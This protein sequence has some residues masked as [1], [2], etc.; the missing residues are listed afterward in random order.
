MP[1]H[2]E[3]VNL[4]SNR[5]RFIVQGFFLSIAVA[6]AD[7]STVLPLIVD[8]FGGGKVLVGVLSSLMKGGAVIM[9]L[10]TAFKA[11]EHPIVLGSLKKVFVFRFLTWFFVG[12]SILIFADFSNTLI[13]ILI[14]IFLF[15]FSFSAG[16]GVIYYQELLGKSFTKEYRGKAISYKQIAAG[17][18]GILSGG[19]S[20]FILERFSKP[21]SF[22]YL[23]LVSGI[24]MA[25]GFL[26]FWNFKEVPKKN[27]LKREQNFGMFLKNAIKLFN[28]DK[29]LK[30][31]VFSRLL[32]Y[33]LFLILPFVILKAKSDFGVSG[34]AVGL[35]IS[36]Q[37]A[38][39]VISNFF[40]G[41]LSG[42]NRN[43]C[44]VLI[45]FV[46]AISAVAL[47][48]IADEFWYFYIVYFLTGAAIDGFRLAFSNLIL[49]ISPED[50]RPMYVAVQNNLSSIGLFFPI[51]GGIIYKSF[52]YT[53][54]SIFT[55]VLLIIGLGISF[56]LR[57]E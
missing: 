42:R 39:A 57:K 38:G 28:S 40:W 55:F 34:K 17:I 26:I 25:I 15:L 5:T 41:R 50:K 1:K 51:L 32:S 18:A 11:Q 21:E 8:Y 44:I 22:S 9:Q 19:L 20:G 45:S 36:V 24:I 54:L 14:S 29:T 35:I 2:S 48:F 49:I 16:V 6:V 31:Q 52:D 12:L 37:M 7:T 13:L 46:L 43:K 4:K 30:I 56:F 23:F 33:S 3:Y 47:T 53:I 10:W 27:T